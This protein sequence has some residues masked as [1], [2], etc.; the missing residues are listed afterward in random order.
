MENLEISKISIDDV[1]RKC[2]EMEWGCIRVKLSDIPD[3]KAV[4]FWD[5]D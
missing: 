3:P 4:H 2:S 1:I 5:E